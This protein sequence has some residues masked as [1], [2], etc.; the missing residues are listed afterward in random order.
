MRIKYCALDQDVFIV[1]YQTANAYILHIRGIRSALYCH[2]IETD[3]EIT[4]HTKTDFSVD[5]TNRVFGIFFGTTAGRI[6]F[7]NVIF[8]L[9]EHIVLKL[10]LVPDSE[11]ACRDRP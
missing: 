1:Q 3:Q 7:F 5:N 8:T 2:E 6:K 11:P 4:C 9:F 10:S